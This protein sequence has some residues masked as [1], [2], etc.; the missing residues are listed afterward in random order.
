ME[1]KLALTEL[2]TKY[3]VEPCEKTQ[4]P[5]RYSTRAAIIT[6]ENGVWLKFKPLKSSI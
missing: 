5:M 4:I 3:E 6:A 2:L 1:M